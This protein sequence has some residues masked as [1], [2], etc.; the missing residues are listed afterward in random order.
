MM[1]QAPM[2]HD[3]SICNQHTHAAMVSGMMMVRPL[4]FVFTAWL[5]LTDT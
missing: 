4:V 5:G 3:A 2:Q 1:P